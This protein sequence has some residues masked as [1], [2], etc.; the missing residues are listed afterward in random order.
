MAVTSVIL[1]V[2]KN[3]FPHKSFG[4]ALALLHT[5]KLSP[6]EELHQPHCLHT[7][8]SCCQWELSGLSEQPPASSWERKPL[9]GPSGT[10]RV[11]GPLLDVPTPTPHSR[12]Q[13][14]KDAPSQR[15][16]LG[17]ALVARGAVTGSGGSQRGAG[18]MASWVPMGPAAKAA[19][20][21]ARSPSAPAALRLRGCSRI[22]CGRRHHRHGPGAAGAHGRAPQQAGARRGGDR[23]RQQEKGQKAAPRDRVWEMGFYFLLVEG[24]VAGAPLAPPAGRLLAGLGRILGAGGPPLWGAPGPPGRAVPA[25]CGSGGAAAAALGRGTCHRRLP[26]LLLGLLLLRRNGRR[27]GA[28]GTPAQSGL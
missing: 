15:A 26:R 24:R 1:S 27:L 8:A 20:P 16:E 13:A 21:P 6:G 14:S 7:H 3:L 4:I 17:M 5:G 25:L 2:H 23:E 12:V 11:G 10:A 28:A 22:C 18:L 19:S 9:P